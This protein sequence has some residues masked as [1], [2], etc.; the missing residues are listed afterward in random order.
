MPRPRRVPRN[1][2]FM[3]KSPTDFSQKARTDHAW[4][5]LQPC[6]RRRTIGKSDGIFVTTGHNFQKTIWQSQHMTD[7]CS[8]YLKN[9]VNY[10]NSTLMLPE[11][12]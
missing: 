4:A 11:S 5:R 7:I 9:E 10:A 6:F 12:V 2:V 3:I 8:K 1:T